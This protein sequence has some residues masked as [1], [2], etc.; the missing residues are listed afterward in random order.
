MYKIYK[1]TDPISK[2]VRYVGKTSN[3]LWKRLVGHV[4]EIDN[5]TKPIF[6]IKNEWILEL[7]IKGYCPLIELLEEVHDSE[8][9]KKEKYWVNYYKDN[10]SLLNIQYNFHDGFSK[11]VKERKSKII[12]EYDIEG[13]YIR[14]WAS[15]TNAAKNYN[16]DDSN[17]CSAA[18]SKR[19]CAGPSMW[20]Y[21]KQEKI[22]WFSLVIAGN[23]VNCST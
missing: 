22:H 15:I 6:S 16:I 3:P 11:S 19:K 4:R 12:Y 7:L 5:Q 17:I 9:N 2:E 23:L 8:A 10:N 1:L 14:E 13:N 20:R 18:S 21:Y